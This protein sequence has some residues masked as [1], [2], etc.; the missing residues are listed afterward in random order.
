MTFPH[1]YRS[2]MFPCL[3]FYT[4]CKLGETPPLH[5]YV[6][7][8]NPIPARPTLPLLQQAYKKLVLVLGSF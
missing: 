4:Y 1:K 8:A 7:R 5:A 3:S 2:F 6:S